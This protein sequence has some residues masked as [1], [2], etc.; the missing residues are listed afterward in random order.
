VFKGYVHKHRIRFGKGQ[1]TK[2]FYEITEKGRQFAR[3]KKFVIPG[4]GEFQHKLWQHTIPSFFEGMHYNAE[5]EKRIG[6][7]NVYV[8]VI[9][10]SH[11]HRE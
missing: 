2:V 7:K 10:M 5:I 8:G 9:Y 11:L 6:T 4:K 1:C 3:M